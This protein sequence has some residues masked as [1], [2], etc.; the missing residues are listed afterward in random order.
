MAHYDSLNIIFE[1]QHLLTCVCYLFGHGILFRFVV[2]KHP[3]KAVVI[4]SL[5]GAKVFPCQLGD[6]GGMAT[7]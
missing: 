2:W 4:A 6:R 7:Y 1:Q 3:F 5:V